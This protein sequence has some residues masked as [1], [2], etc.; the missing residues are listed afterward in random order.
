MKTLHP[1]RPVRRLRQAG[2]SLA[3]LM[4]VI[5]ILGLLATVVVPRVVGYLGKASVTVAKMDITSIA[6][7]IKNYQIQN[8]GRLP[9]S[10]DVLIQKDDDG[11]QF[12]ELD[13]LPVDPW[14]NEYEYTPEYDGPGTFRV[15]SYGADGEPGGEGEN[16]DI[17]DKSAKKRSRRS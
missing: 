2:F 14:G 8:G 13:E 3:E 10:L 5:V 11:N 17:D 12:L 6:E 7:A 16:A 1:T 15:L 9:E 4:V